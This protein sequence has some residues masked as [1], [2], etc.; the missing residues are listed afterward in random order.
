MLGLSSD[1]SVQCWVC[2][3][4]GLSSVGSVQCWV[5]PVLGLSSAGSVQC[6][7]TLACPVLGLSSVGSVQCWVC[8]V[9]SYSSLSSAVSAVR[10]D[11]GIQ[12]AQG[13]NACDNK[14]GFRPPPSFPDV[15]LATVASNKEKK[16]QLQRSKSIVVRRN[17]QPL[18]ALLIS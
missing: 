1:G 3:V 16:N 9:P 12:G 5:C 14:C 17:G 10:C 15:A 2:P 4:L 18:D 7:R 11:N 13:A 6:H 8:P